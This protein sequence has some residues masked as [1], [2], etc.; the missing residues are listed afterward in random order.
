[1]DNTKALAEAKA[2]RSQMEGILAKDGY[3][4]QDK[5]EV[6][7]LMQKLDSINSKLDAMSSL[8]SANPDD[9]EAEEGDEEGK[10]DEGERSYPH[11]SVLRSRGRQSSPVDIHDHAKRE[12]FNVVRAGADFLERGKLTG[13]EAEVSA[14]LCRLDGGC[15]GAFK[16]PFGDARKL[17]DKDWQT[18]A[19][20]TLSTGAGAIPS[21]WE[22]SLVDYLY[23]LMVGPLLG[24]DYITGLAGVTNFPRQSGVPTVSAVAEQGNAT[25]SNATL[26]DVTFS[27][28]T[29]TG[30]VNVSRKFIMQSVVPANS[31]I[32]NALAK[33][34]AVQMDAYALTADGQSNRPTGLFNNAAVTNITVS[35]SNAVSWSDLVAME[36]QVEEGNANIGNLAYLG[37]PAAKAKLRTTAR[38]GTTY[39]IFLV[40]D[41]GN[42]NGHPLIASSQVPKNLSYT[43][44]ANLTAL[45][46]GNWKDLAVAT[47]GNGV[48]MLVNPYT[49]ANKGDVQFVALLDMDTA[50]FHAASFAIIPNI[51]P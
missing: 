9:P 2:I 15:N 28:H 4:E 37:S 11:P 46:Y 20:Q 22:N 5:R 39:P 18:R 21:Y 7:A 45:A 49:G 41:T 51:L 40:D 23:P 44:L 12:D 34:I 24:F 25:A 27:P 29:I 6:D 17:N 19:D 35:T 30:N 38:I 1:M 47:F 33:Q 31:Y 26:D 43:G 10:E 32:M 13:I 42:I 50:L 14:E 8:L 3:S 16:I 48:D 36:K